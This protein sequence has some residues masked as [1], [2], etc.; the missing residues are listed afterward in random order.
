[1]YYVLFIV[2]KIYMHLSKYND[3]T[4]QCNICSYFATI[5]VPLYAPHITLLIPVATHEHD[6]STSN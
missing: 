1:M 6:R 3:Q 5:I 2:T 4:E